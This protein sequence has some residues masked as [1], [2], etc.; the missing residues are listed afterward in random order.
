MRANR[1]LTISLAALAGLIAGA[2]LSTSGDYAADNPGPGELLCTKKVMDK[3]YVGNQSLMKMVRRDIENRPPDWTGAERN[4]TEVMRLMSMLTRQK[5]PR[6]SQ[7]AW[8]GLVE[9]YRQKARALK[10]NVKEQ[11]LQASR[12]SLQK[13]ASTCDEC[14]DNHGIQ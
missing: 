6:G 12:A 2:M 10:Q 7:E 8:D 5:P 4:V 9:D 14:H 13:I 1:R 3:C 11:K